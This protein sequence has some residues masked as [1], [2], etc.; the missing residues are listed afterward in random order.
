MIM[1]KPEIDVIR[2]ECS[3]IVAASSGIKTLTWTG[4]EDKIGN[5]NY[6]SFGGNSYLIQSSSSDEFKTMRSDLADYFGDDELET[7]TRSNIKFG[8]KY[9]LNSFI[10][11]TT[12]LTGAD[13]TYRYD[14][15]KIFTKIS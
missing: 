7:T 11:N 4:L 12:A 9:T 3:D 5:N 14:G 6:V 8:N 1:K 13:G 2:F 10:G 15:N